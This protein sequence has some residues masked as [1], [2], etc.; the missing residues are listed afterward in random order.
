M[1]RR[2][3]R[4]RRSGVTTLIAF[5]VLA[6]GSAALA[7]T[8][9]AAAPAVGTCTVKP[10]DDGLS[11]TISGSGW[12]P[13]VPLK[14]DGGEGLDSVAVSP[15]GTFSLKRF[16][17]NTDF[18]ILPQAENGPA[19]VPCKVLK[20]DKQENSDKIRKARNDGFREGVKAGKAAAQENC[21]SDKPKPHRHHQGLTAEDAAVEE[22]FNQGFLAGATS[23]FDKFCHTGH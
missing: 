6:G 19:F 16:Q 21:K 18:V 4:I 23:A 13:Q 5:S 8:A 15:E 9:A 12:D 10:A 17:K 3:R 14:I 11:I 2:T 22:A 7:S 20:A 1:N